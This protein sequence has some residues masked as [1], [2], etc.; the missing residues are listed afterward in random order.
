MSTP[1]YQATLKAVARLDF[2]IKHLTSVH[3]PEPRSSRWTPELSRQLVEGMTACRWFLASGFDPPAQ[4]GAWLRNNL[5][6]V[7]LQPGSKNGDFYGAAVWHAAAEVD[8]LGREWQPEWS[9]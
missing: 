7:G 1:Q 5:E 6:Q 3:D 9:L 4:F 2:A 8:H